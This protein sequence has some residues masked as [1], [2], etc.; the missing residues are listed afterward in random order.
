MWEFAEKGAIERAEMGSC[1]GNGGSHHEDVLILR[2][3]GGETKYSG[4]DVI[5]RLDGDSE[6]LGG[7]TGRKAVLMPILHRHRGGG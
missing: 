1:R 4:L 7:L 2:V 6:I 3:Y 5:D